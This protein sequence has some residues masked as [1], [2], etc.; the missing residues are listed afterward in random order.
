M[1]N[2]I[3]NKNEKNY[4]L[5][6]YVILL[7]SPG[8]FLEEGYSATKSPIASKLMR[9][10]LTCI[11]EIELILLNPDRDI[12]IELINS[13]LV[14]VDID[15]YKNPNHDIIFG[16]IQKLTIQDKLFVIETPSK[17]VHIYFD[18]G[19]INLNH[20]LKTILYNT[21]ENIDILRQAVIGPNFHSR[22]IITKAH[23]Y[24]RTFKFPTITPFWFP[25]SKKQSENFTNKK[26]NIDIIA[27]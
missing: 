16:V 9:R 26:P 8:I 23:D 21:L 13:N 24:F 14:V 6:F 4:V 2:E 22:R 3:I 11:K 19:T 7:K 1:K 18:L 5:D 15:F 17:G 20:Q 10:R 27:C 25:L 12:R